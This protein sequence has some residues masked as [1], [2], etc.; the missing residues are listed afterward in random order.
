MYVGPN[1]V[2]KC[3][4]ACQDAQHERQTAVRVQ[5]HENRVNAFMNPFGYEQSVMFRTGATAG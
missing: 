4:N 1:H 5:N 3:E 2:E